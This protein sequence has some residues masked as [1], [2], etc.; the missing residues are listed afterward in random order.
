MLTDKFNDFLIT[1]ILNP[2]S[3]WLQ[4]QHHLNVSNRQ[5]LEVINNP[6]PNTSH[7]CYIYVRGDKRGLQCS[8]TCVEGKNYCSTHLRNKKVNHKVLKSPKQESNNIVVES[9]HYRGIPGLYLESTN[10]FILQQLPT[11]E[12]VVL[13]KLDGDKE[14]ELTEEE[15][16]IAR[17]MG[18]LVPVQT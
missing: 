11:G 18:I 1:N 4:E 12:V 10:H 13:N 9:D 14:R 8:N 2:I 3:R 6:Q 17:R 15:K 5:L 7:C 16:E